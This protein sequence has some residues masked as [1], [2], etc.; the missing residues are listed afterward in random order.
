M[1]QPKLRRQAA[2]TIAQE[3]TT[4][5]RIALRT[6]T[7]MIPTDTID[8]NQDAVPDATTT[9]AMIVGM[10]IITGRAAKS[11]TAKHIKHAIVRESNW[12]KRFTGPAAGASSSF[13]LL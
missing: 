7:I 12:L 3:T 6:M 10:A 4:T 1:A 8:P 9:G 2:R 11:Y 5:G 13:V